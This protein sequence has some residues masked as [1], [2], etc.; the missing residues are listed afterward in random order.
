MASS[1]WRH[2]VDKHAVTIREQVHLLK[3][4]KI[5]FC[6]GSRDAIERGAHVLFD[7]ETDSREDFLHH[8]ASGLNQVL[9]KSAKKNDS[10]IAFN[11]NSI[12]ET[13]DVAR[14]KIM[15]RM[16]QNIRLC[17]KY[18]VPMLPLSFA[19]V[20]FQMRALLDFKAFFLDLGMHPREIIDGQKHFA[21][22]LDKI[23]KP[24]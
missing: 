3:K 14:A 12:L 17:R 2:T 20:P 8:R 21:N 23:R 22:L 15:G 10:I 11:F 18:K 5:V 4:S 16:Q 19:A 13:D 6:K 24:L 7:F 9:C 1:S